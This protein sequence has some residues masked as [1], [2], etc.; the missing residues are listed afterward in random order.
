MLPS[1]SGRGFGAEHA[2]EARPDKLHAHELF[3]HR[4]GIANVDHAAT[5]GEVRFGSARSVVRERYANFQVRTY[6]HVKARQKRRAAA[7][8][9][10]AGSF[11]FEA[12]AARVAPAHAHRQVDR[13]PTFRALSRNAGAD[14]DH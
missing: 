4:C 13:D 2:L 9:I 6:S 5:G 3:A 7:A 10:F 14:W 8:K 11:F 1:D 12:D